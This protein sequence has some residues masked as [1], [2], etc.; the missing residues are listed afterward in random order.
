M[1]GLDEEAAA[2]LTFTTVGFVTGQL[3]LT[4]APV[5]V[6][7]RVAGVASVQLTASS[8]TTHAAVLRAASSLTLATML[9]GIGRD[10][11]AILWILIAVAV[12]VGAAHDL[13]RAIATHGLCV[14]E[15]AAVSSRL[16][17]LPIAVVV[18]TI[19]DFEARVPGARGIAVTVGYGSVLGRLHI[20][21]ARA[22]RAAIV[23]LA[24]R[25]KQCEQHAT[26][27]TDQSVRAG[28]FDN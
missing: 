6:A 23:H 13:T 26:D 10:L 24:S 25:R 11:T 19:A 2:A 17:D 4:A 27:R 16:V 9:Y 28:A 8:D 7:I 20:R 14:V 21:G 12:V 3:D 18:A 15:H 22:R 5:A 1:R